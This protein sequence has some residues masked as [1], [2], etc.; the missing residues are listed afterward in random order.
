MKCYVGITDKQWFDSLRANSSVRE[1]NFWQPG[2]NRRF[3][4]LDRG[5]L[6]LFK[7]HSPDNFIV[8]GAFFQYS[9][10]MPI[11]LAWK[12]F[13][14]GNGVQGLND[15]RDRTLKYR[16]IS[17]T[18]NDFIVGC[19]LLSDPF[20][21]SEDKWIPIPSDW[22]PNIVSGKKYDLTAE[23]GLTLYKQILINLK[24]DKISE[25]QAPR[26]GAK[27]GIKPRLGQ[28]TFRFMITDAYERQ[29]A[30][31][32]EKVLPVLEA[33][34]VKL[35]SEGGG[36]SLDNGVLMRSDL[37]TLFDQGYL[38]ITPERRI[39]VSSKI[40]EEFENGKEYYAHQGRELRTPIVPGKPIASDNITWHNENVYLG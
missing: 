14:I 27:I 2:G 4:A 24:E 31:S 1:L 5:D 32:G 12:A 17:E 30:I 23:P 10:L 37:H 3:R 28:G 6:F 29:C 20:Y 8:G 19:I 34:H 33:A 21:F 13:D 40:R 9:T 26:Y 15:M 22:K 39:E 35:Y 16:R 11:S 38:T 25:T 18:R 36:H 7:L